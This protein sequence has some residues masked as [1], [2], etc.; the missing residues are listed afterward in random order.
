MHNPFEGVTE[1]PEWTKF[2]AGIG[3]ETSS[4]RLALAAMIRFYAPGPRVVLD[5]GCGPGMS[6]KVIRELGMEWVG[7]EPAKDLAEK[8]G[9]S[10]S[11]FPLARVPDV[12]MV[13]HVLEHIPPDDLPRE[14]SL[15]A[16]IGASFIAVALS[17]PASERGYPSDE[18]L[19]IPRWSHKEDSLSFPGYS[20]KMA[21][22]LWDNHA[23]EEFRFF[24]K[25]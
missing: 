9:A 15:I 8:C 11:L 12:V 5:Y 20:L 21:R 17:V 19:G 1:R 23:P 10:Q 22:R 24:E 2:L 6:R 16:S 7:Y 14:L 13:R 25:D 18:Y 4:S 3:H